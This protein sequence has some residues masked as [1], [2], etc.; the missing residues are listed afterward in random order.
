MTDQFAALGGVEDFAEHPIPKPFQWIYQIWLKPRQVLKAIV[1]QEKSVWLVPLGLISILQIVKSAIE[2][3]IHSAVAQVSQAAA[4]MPVEEMGYLTEQEIAQIQQGAATTNGPFFTIVIPAL[5]SVLG[6]WIS[7]VLLG[8]IL[9]LGLTLAGNRNNAGASLNLSAWASLPL[10][11]R[12]IV[13]IIATAATRQVISN[14]GL[15]G[16]LSPQGNFGIFIAVV[17]SL[18]DIYLIWQVIYLIIGARQMGN[19]ARGRVIFTVIACVVI[20]LLLQAVP[21]T[22]SQVISGMSF[23]RPYFF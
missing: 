9:H 13:Q 22:I 10:A 2:G 5:L 4:G 19:I 12:I 6:I 20:V 23:S 14:P 8:S 17:L 1:Q 16:F 7:W 15:S 3:P 21:G 11:I 18:L